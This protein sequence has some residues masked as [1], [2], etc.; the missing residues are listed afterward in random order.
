MFFRKMLLKFRNNNA[1][2]RLKRLKEQFPTSTVGVLAHTENA[3]LESENVIL[4]GAD[5]SGSQIGSATV[6]GPNSNLINCKIGRFCSIS[7]GVTVVN[8]THP[9]DMVS[10]YPGFFNTVN[11]YPFGR[12]NAEKCEFLKTKD[13]YNVVIGNDVW[14]GEGVTIKG[15]VT[16]GDGAVIGMRAVVTKDVPPYAIV[17]GVPAKVLRYRMKPEEIKKML[18]IRWWDWPLDL[19]KE[20]REEFVNIRDFINKY[21]Q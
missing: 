18:V 20:R 9:L 16:I 13:G 6:I 12:G 5:I 10:T 21:G 11:D 17:G 7:W 1:K 8:A 3:V 2:R 14:V 19:I 4:D 15:G